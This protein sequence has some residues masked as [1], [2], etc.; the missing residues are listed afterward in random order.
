MTLAESH[1]SWGCGSVSYLTVNSL[2][3]LHISSSDRQSKIVRTPMHK[4]ASVGL[5]P[6]L[7]KESSSA[8]TAFRILSE[9]NSRFRFKDFNRLS[10][11]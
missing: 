8:L 2:T 5:P 3:F 4:I 7:K 9:V 10:H 1:L 11:R 6:S